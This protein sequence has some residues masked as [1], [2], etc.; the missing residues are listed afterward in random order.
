MVEGDSCDHLGIAADDFDYVW[1]QACL[2]EDLV[3]QIACV[4][5]E[6]RGIPEDDVS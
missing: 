4:D 5:V 1:G 2:A 6:G 3:D